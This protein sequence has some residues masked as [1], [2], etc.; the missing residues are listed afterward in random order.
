ML[1]DDLDRKYATP[2]YDAHPEL[3]RAP[4]GGIDYNYYRA[5]GRRERAAAVRDAA[6]ALGRLIRRAF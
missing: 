1:A 3:R 4:D 6:S 2:D 5:L